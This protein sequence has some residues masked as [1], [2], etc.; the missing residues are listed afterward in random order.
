MG[1]D[2]GTS[3]IITGLSMNAF[4]VLIFLLS[5][6]SW[7]LKENFKIQ[8]SNIIAQNKLSLK[9]LEREMGLPTGTAKLKAEPTGNIIDL[10][11]NLDMDKIQGILELLGA[12]EQEQ[13]ENPTDTLI[14]MVTENPELISKFLG[15]L[16]GQ[17]A[18]NIGETYL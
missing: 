5:Q 11:K 8:K 13:S 14:K 16:K 7:F 12:G 3:I 9:K 1:I 6:R 2:L 10:V 17:N 18:S 15:G 4:F